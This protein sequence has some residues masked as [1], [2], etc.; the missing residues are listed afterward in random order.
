M[1]A[2][3]EQAAPPREAVRIRVHGS[4][5]AARVMTKRTAAVGHV[6]ARPQ[7]ALVPRRRRTARLI[8]AVCAPVFALMLGA[9]AFQTQLAS[10]Q[11][12]LDTV[13]RQIR[14][15]YD[16]YDLMRRE[17]AELR[18]PGRLATEAA[19]LGMVPAEQTQ[20]LALD[21]DIIA[22]V[23]RSGA[24]DDQAAPTGLGE[25]FDQYADVK[26]QSSGAP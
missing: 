9:A 15:A 21:P 26:A 11:L 22:T 12:R 6:S 2:R 10:R 23:Q 18:S 8:A 13:D 3:S 19:A 7:L 25:E 24:A 5:V 16:Q 14:A 4:G 17:R 1:A 20:F